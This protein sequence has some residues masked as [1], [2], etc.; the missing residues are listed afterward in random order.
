MTAYVPLTDKDKCVL[1][2]VARQA[3]HNTVNR[4]TLPELKLSDY[5]KVLQ[6]IGASFVTLT[7]AG[8][9]RGCI[10]TIDPYQPLVQDVCEHAISAALEDYRFYPVQPEDVPYIRIEISRLSPLKKLEYSQSQD[11]LVLLHPGMDGVV[12]RDGLRRATFLPQVWEKIDTVEGF[13]EQLC[14]KMGAQGDYWRRKKLDVY[15]YQVEKFSEETAG[16]PGRPGER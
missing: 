4:L 6:E 12:I 11:L 16:K 2:H 7:E 10:G 8:N 13:L 5:S 14:Y 3:I 15:I 9:L 1:L